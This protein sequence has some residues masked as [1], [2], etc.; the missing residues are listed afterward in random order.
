[1]KRINDFF[2]VVF[3]YLLFVTFV[4]ADNPPLSEQSEECISCH[5]EIHPGIISQWQQSRHAHYTPEMGFKKDEMER[6]V[7]T[8]NISDT[9]QKVVVGCYECH[10]INPDQHK[11]TFE[12]NGYR[13]HTIVTP[14]DCAACHRREVREYSNNLMAEAYGNLMKNPVYQ[15]LLHSVNGPAKHQGKKLTFGEPMQDT[16]AESCL[17]CHGTHIEVKGTQTRET[18]FGEM[19]FPVL[20]N[21]PNQGV[22]RL[23]PDGSKGSCTSC[24]SRHDFSIAMARK[25][26]TC[27][28]CHKGPDV[29]AYKVY[30]VSK[31]GNIYEAHK[32]EWDFEAVPWKVGEDFTAPTCAACHVS[33]LADGEGT[34]IA[35]RTHQFND[36][37][38][39][40]IFGAPYAHAHPKSADLSVIKNKA[41]LPLATELDGRPVNEYL[42]SE[43]EQEENNRRMQAVCLSCH[44]SGWVENHFARLE[45]SIMETNQSVKTA[46]ELMTE[47]WQ[48]GSADQT[49]MF[50][51]YIERQWTSA[52][53][54]YANS[55]RFTSAMAGGGD[56]GVFAEG[57]YQL[58][59]KIMQLHAW[60]KSHE[61]KK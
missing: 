49:N 56:Y 46:T 28:E 5:S 55:T 57:R 7:S 6:R 8:K 42:I 21:W 1:M 59:E 54:F 29:P 19:D 16:N 17:Y 47:I 37:L 38:A 27:S 23:N 15:Q 51:E 10:S 36:R 22:G 50:D 61:H 41:G 25:P 35:E 24:H 4:I 43:Q 14:N 11:D 2:Y 58:S 52:W 44:S 18:Q 32:K 34:V 40:R 13:V 20:D 53:L 3:L 9:L 26:A 30:Q 60:L 12:H 45:H 48:N 39:W 31:H 33:L